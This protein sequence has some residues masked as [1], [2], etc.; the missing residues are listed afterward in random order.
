LGGIQAHGLI[1]LKAISR[2]DAKPQVKEKGL[3]NHFLFL[4][5]CG[6][7]ALRD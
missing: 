6:F 2:R 7:A 1:L 3:I 4:R 5:L